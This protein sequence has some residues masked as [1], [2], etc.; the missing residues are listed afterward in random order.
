MTGVPLQACMHR[1]MRRSG[2]IKKVRLHRPEIERRNRR[3]L[4]DLERD[5]TADDRVADFD[6]LPPQVKS[7]PNRTVVVG[8]TPQTIGQSSEGAEHARTVVAARRAA[9]PVEGG[10]QRRRGCS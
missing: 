6:A 3:F 9:L 7:A 4:Q 1:T 8:V 10:E 5:G 2:R